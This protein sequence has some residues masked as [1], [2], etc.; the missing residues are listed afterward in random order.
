MK[1]LILLTSLSLLISAFGD[2]R[3]W[4][5]SAGTTIEAK[6]V[7]NDMGQVNLLTKEGRTLKIKLSKFSKA[8]QAYLKF[9]KDRKA[10]EEKGFM[11]KVQT[12]TDAVEDFKG[13]IFSAID[14][15]LGMDIQSIEFTQTSYDDLD[16]KI[17]MTKPLVNKDEEYFLALYFNID[18]N[19]QTGMNMWRL[20]GADSKVIIKGRSYEKIYPIDFGEKYYD[21]DVK[22][23]IYPY[24]TPS[25]LLDVKKVKNKGNELEFTV[26]FDS[27]FEGEK[28]GFV[29]NSVKEGV[30]GSDDIF[31]DLADGKIELESRKK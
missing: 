19:D 8:D 14:A 11:D 26:K 21:P 15:E 6:L 4:T 10:E 20:Q 28:M 12:F 25:K 23:D 13:S 7:S 16:V 5:S 22:R 30:N 1:K 3:Q 27:D 29:L 9:I 2:F 31:M 24:I 17:Q 18:S